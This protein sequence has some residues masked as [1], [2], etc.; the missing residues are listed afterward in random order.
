MWANIGGY[1]SMLLGIAFLQ[2]PDVILFIYQYLQKR[3]EALK[4]KRFLTIRSL[5]PVLQQNTKIGQD[6]TET[7]NNL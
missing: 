7:Q 6:A 3:K 2:V 5:I 4:E 1:V